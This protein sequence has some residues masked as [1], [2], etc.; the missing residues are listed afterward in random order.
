MNDK[1][2]ALLGIGQ[3]LAWTIAIF[4]GTMISTAVQ[5]QPMPLPDKAAHE[6]L[7]QQQRDRELREQM[8]SAPNARLEEMGQLIPNETRIPDQE[9]P[10]FTIER[11]ELMGELAEKFQWALK[12]ADNGPGRSVDQATG[13]C[14]GAQGINTVMSRV[15]NAIIEKGYITTR[16]FAAPQDLNEGTLTL[17]LVPGRIRSIRWGEGSQTRTSWRAALPMREGDLLNLRDLEQALE[18]FKRVPTADADIQ[19]EPG[20]QAGESDLVLY[21][22]QKFP[23]RLNLSVDDGGSRDTG[24]YQGALTLSYDNWLTM[25]DL[26]YVSLN[27]HLADSQGGNSRGYALHYSIPFDGDWLLSFNG[28]YYKY[29]Q[30]IAGINQSYTY[31]GSSQN[32]D[33][34]LSRRIYRDS[35]KRLNAYIKGW[36]RRSHNYIDDVEIEVQRRRTAGWEIGADYR[37]F[38]GNAILNANLSYRRGTGADNALP[39][40]EEQ[41]GEGTSRMKIVNL[42]ATLNVPWQ[43]GSQYFRYYGTLRVQWNDTPLI[44]Q[45]QFAIGGR[46]TVRGFDGRNN[47]MGDR[48]WLT[49]NDVGWIIGNTGQELYFGLDFGCVSGQATR[50][51]VGQNLAGAVIGLR[52]GYGHVSYDAFVG[53][54]LH[55]PDGFE[56]SKFT[57]GFNVNVWF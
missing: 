34:S 57:S 39:A 6:L 54:P 13:R 40:L 43:I 8:G 35:S 9:S 38:I 32:A 50:Y 7:L 2:S 10:C 21:W 49:R 53:T 27:H 52:G 44:P 20:A 5:A 48:G 11:I 4:T 55:K 56:T 33:I 22:Q 3:V 16:I 30:D 45:D 24:R 47:L 28:S 37:Q 29:E 41:Y 46:Y 14:L 23:F 18:V 1:R 25:N 42:N 17:T 12:A 15:Q 31:R 26:F 36:T 19:I 51:Q